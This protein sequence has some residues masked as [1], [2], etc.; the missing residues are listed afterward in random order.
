[1]G[2]PQVVFDK[3]VTTNRADELC[4]IGVAREVAAL[5][6][7]TL[8]IPTTDSAGPDAPAVEVKVSDA[9]CFR[10]RAQS[11]SVDVGPSPEWMQRYLR[12][13]G[14][15]PINNVVDI[16]NF[17]M[18]EFGQPLH[19]YDSDRLS[20]NVLE[21]RA[22]QDGEAITTLDGVERP[23]R[24]GMLVIA[25]EHSSVGIAGIMGGMASKIDE[26]TKHITLEAAAFDPVVIRRAANQLAL[27][28][29]AS[30]R[31]E[32]LVDR[33]MTPQAL[34]RACQLLRDHAAA[35]AV[36]APA[37]IYPQPQEERS[38][39]LS[40]RKLN[41]YTST[42]VTLKQA[43][44]ILTSL[45]FSPSRADA[46]G[47]TKEYIVPSWRLRDVEQEE[48]LIEE[49]VRVVGYPNIPAVLPS[50][51]IPAVPINGEVTSRQRL[52]RWLAEAGYW[53]TMSL[54]LVGP[55]DEAQV[56][57]SNPLSAD[58]T[59]LRRTLA[60]SLLGAAGRNVR[61]AGSLRLFEL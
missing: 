21:A 22:A 51:T 45:G 14:M 28:S 54:S 18:L 61:Q 44:D 36:S 46:D 32:R 56:A 5:T 38:V 23:L 52:K 42:S 12:L 58:W 7:K 25:D 34:S 50:G 27:R 60:P 55:D 59:H 48:D 41:Q 11:M 19:A 1:L 57:V 39:S 10:L 35:S 3:E 24:P 20:G 4:I 2:Y 40:S 15:R 53:E 26:S 31:F 37:D 33:S 6:G 17:V 13:S 47:S 29:E 49:V 43:D 16:T 8:K 9:A 30:R